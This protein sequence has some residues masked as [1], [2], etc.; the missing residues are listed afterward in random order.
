[1]NAF[2]I[3]A[4]LLP[5]EQ[6]QIVGGMDS[7]RSCKCSTGMLPTV[8]KLA[9]CPLGGGTLIHGKLSVEKP[10]SVVVLDTQTGVP[11]S[12]CTPFKSTNIFLPICLCAI[13]RA[14]FFF[15][16]E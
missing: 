12:Y 8:V 14:I 2:L 13:Q 9:G 7:T 5:L 11:G 3:V 16:L 6:H 10:S 4:Q 15:F 1:M